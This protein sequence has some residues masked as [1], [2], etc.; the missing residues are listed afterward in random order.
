MKG[1]RHPISGK[2]VRIDEVRENSFLIGNVSFDVNQ[3][4]GDNT[5]THGIVVTLTPKQAVKLAD[6]LLTVA[7]KIAGVEVLMT[8]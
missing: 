3:Y 5:F 8:K 6:K 7:E 2:R 1:V 4:L